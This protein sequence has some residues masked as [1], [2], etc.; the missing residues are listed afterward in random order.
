MV[1]MVVYSSADG[2]MVVYSNV[3]YSIRI[4]DHEERRIFFFYA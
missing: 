1:A 4:I 3:Q 2:M